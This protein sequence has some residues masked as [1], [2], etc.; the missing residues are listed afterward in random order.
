MLPLQG[1]AIGQ[2]QRAAADGGR[3]GKGAGGGEGQGVGAELGQT[4]V[5]GNGTAG[6]AACRV[7]GVDAEGR[8]GGESAAVG[9]K[10]GADI[11]GRPTGPPTLSASI[12]P[13]FTVTLEAVL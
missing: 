11:A 6:E 8:A 7:G 13:L 10:Q 1:I 2:I 9:G 3:S 12:P 5:A 4:H